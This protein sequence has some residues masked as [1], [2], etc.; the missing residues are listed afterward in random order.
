MSTPASFLAAMPKVFSHSAGSCMVMRFV[1]AP[2]RTGVVPSSVT[3]RGFVAYAGN[4][5]VALAAEVSGSQEAHF[6]IMALNDLP[7]APGSASV[8]GATSD[9]AE[10]TLRRNPAP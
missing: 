8:F 2:P 1:I 4:M 7:N 6:S 10:T 5:Y 3:S 9:G